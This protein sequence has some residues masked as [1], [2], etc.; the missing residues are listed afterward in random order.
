M[1]RIEPGPVSGK[2]VAPASK[3]VT[4]RAY[5][6]ASQAERP[7]TVMAPLR[8]RDTDATLAGLHRLGAR[9]T[10]ADDTVRFEPAPLT[11]PV[12]AVDCRNSGTT[13]R[14]LAAAAARLAAP[15]RFIGDASLSRR[16]SEPL[17][18]ALRRL[19]V[20]VESRDGCAP[21]LVRGPLRPGTV[22]LP[23]HSSSQFASGLALSLACLDGPSTLRLEAPIDSAPYLDLTLAMA[24]QSGLVLRRSSNAEGQEWAIAPSRPR[25]GRLAVEGD[26]SSAAFLFAAAAVTGGSVAVA[27]LD[28]ASLQP[29]R[30]ILA[31]LRAFGC[32]VGADS[33]RS[34]ALDSPGTI[35]L[36]SSPDL[37]PVLA[38]VAAFARGTTLLVCGPQLRNKESDRI[39]AMTN[40]LRAMGIQAREERDTLVV[41][42]GKPHGAA[43]ASHGDHRIHMALCVAALA[44]NGTSTLDGDA[45]AAVS[46]PGFHD[47]LAALGARIFKDGKPL[48]ATA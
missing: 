28:A 20:H 37:L 40:G 18:A 9:M 3:S 16:T 38:V 4:H 41:E 47:A 36:R 10:M 48:E 26:W 12:E 14:F 15:V 34:A 39:A 8:S 23:A 24:Q 27:G 22:T 32:E 5:L 29:D 46:Y 44:A 11:A 35:D 21:V 33:V 31:H 13:L 6:L 2:A 1:M 43:L 30:A 25:G 45:T 17:W 7:T 42:G 19:G